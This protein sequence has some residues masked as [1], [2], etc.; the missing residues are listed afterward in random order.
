M[1]VA[2]TQH[3][4]DRAAKLVQV[5]YKNVKKPLLDIKEAKNDSSRNTLIRTTPAKERGNNIVKTIKGGNTIYGQYHFVMETLVCVTKPTEEGIEVHTA[6]QW[7]DG[8]QVMISRALN[9]KCN[10]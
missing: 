8:T 1:I 5:Q 10:Q 2:E 7:M 4:A 9:M 6:G 3:I